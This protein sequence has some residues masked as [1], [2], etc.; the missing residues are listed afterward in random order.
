[1]IA[2]DIDLAVLEPT[3]FLPQ[4]E[5]GEIDVL[6]STGNKPALHEALADVPL[7]SDLGAEEPFVTQVRLFFGAPDLSE[8]QEQYWVD[9]L[10]QWSES[11]G[12]AAYIEENAL[13]PQLITGDELDTYISESV[14][15]LAGE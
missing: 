3:E 15:T 8:A 11:D 5:A 1:M 2:G 6:L 4:V 14:E 10:T 7:A 9:V 13:T 12:Y